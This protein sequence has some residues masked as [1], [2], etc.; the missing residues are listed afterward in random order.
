MRTKAAFLAL[1]LC[2]LPFSPLMETEEEQEAGFTFAFGEAATTGRQGSVTPPLDPTV[3]FRFIQN[4][5]NIE[6][7]RMK[8]LSEIHHVVAI[9]ALGEGVASMNATLRGQMIV[10]IQSYQNPD[11]GFGDWDGDRSKAGSTRMAVETLSLLGA[12]PLDSTGVESFISRLQVNGLAYGNHGFRSSI[13]E[14][15]ADISTTWDAVR[16]LSLLGH[17]VPNA[18]GVIQY[19]HD[20]RNDDGGYGYQTNRPAG[21]HWQSTTLHTQRALST[22]AILNAEPEF[23]LETRNFVLS[24]QN[25]GGGFAN[26]PMDSARVAYTRNAL[27]ALA[28]LAE[29]VPRSDDVR[30]FVHLNQMADGGWVEYD[31]DLQTGL[32]S[33]HF[34][35]DA[36][37]H[38]G[39]DSSD[40]TATEYAR[41]VMSTPMDGGFGNQPGMDSNIRVTFDAITALNLIG[42]SPN[43]RTAASG[44]LLSARNVDGGYGFGSSSVESTYRAV[45]GLARL[46]TTAPEPEETIAFLRGSQ[47][48]DGGF[49]FAPG[50]PST[51]AYTYRA[52]QAL[53]MLGSQA[54]DPE[55]AGN[56]IRNLQQSNGGFGNTLGADPGLGSTYRALRTL[57]SLDVDPIDGPGAVD[58]LLACENPDGG[59][60]SSPESRVSPGNLSTAIRTY[61]ARG[62]LMHLNDAPATH[63][64]AW[65]FLKSL[66]N[67]DLGFGEKPD[68]TSEVD[69]SFLAVQLA[70]WLEANA[71]AGPILLGHHVNRTNL[72]A[73]ENASFTVNFTDPHGVRPDAILLDIDGVRTPMSLSATL[74]ATS[75]VSRNLSVGVHQVRFIVLSRGFE[76]ISPQT[77]VRVDPIG[78]PP[79]VNI[80]VDQA[81]GDID[82]HFTFRATFVDMDGDAATSV[83]LQ[84]DRA[85][86]HE[87]V[88]V[89]GIQDG[90]LHE[91]SLQL[92]PGR[93]SV[94]VRVSDGINVVY[95]DNLQA[96]LVHHPDASRPDWLTFQRIEALI[97]EEKGVQIEV[98]DV[99]AT[100]RAGQQAWAVVLPE[101]VV[102]VDAS[103]ERI[104]PEESDPEFQP[105]L[106]DP[107]VLIGGG[108]LLV[109][110][111]LALAFGGRRRRGGGR[112]KTADPWAAEHLWD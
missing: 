96:P 22:L 98:D 101:E 112:R 67:P 25:A 23:V 59:F 24:T 27:T 73:G 75:S 18:T 62:A 103:G 55:G 82:T 79:T 53:H 81:E 44:F 61:N 42:R 3:S 64:L 35:L 32:H 48:A 86:W 26:T 83:R 15:D 110:L 40:G 43:N 17:P 94:R 97:L 69:D 56:Y 58:W 78:Q 72:I 90:S 21:I 57:D 84:V 88:E 54:A 111:L 16:A 1:L 9:Y 12:I 6:L 41:Q 70:R 66:R 20:H 108:G 109:V 74:P 29:P 68:F 60:R 13:K 46:G 80:S 99:S 14:S 39:D 11:G 95:S 76:V 104:L 105:I 50:R 106:I 92:P 33:T 4:S 34:A 7:N 19:V 52:V 45:A 2:L 30:Q 93:H 71:S 87:M 100:I 107:Q 85:D 38:L 65:N 5:Q 10:R 28:L 77:T 91:V 63:P 31:L 36:L 47:N 37:Q 49:G 51:G 102:F 89:G 8:D